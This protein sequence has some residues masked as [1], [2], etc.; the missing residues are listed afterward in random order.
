ME[1]KSLEVTIDLAEC[2]SVQKQLF[3]D[4]L[5]SK[6]WAKKTTDQ[7][8]LLNTKKGVSVE[9]QLFL[10]EKDLV[11]AQ[12]ISLV[13]EIDYAVIFSDGFYFNSLT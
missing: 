3:V 7:L 9:K 6:N 2:T 4:C 10:I 8:W 11:V 13:T 1:K 12:K 5:I